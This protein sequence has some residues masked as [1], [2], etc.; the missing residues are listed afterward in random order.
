MGRENEELLKALREHCSYGDQVFVAEVASIDE[1]LDTVVI[2]VNGLELSSVRLRS[3]IDS[4]GN[5]VV[6]YP[7]VDSTVLVGRIGH[8]N[9]M[10]VQAV[11]VVDKVLC[12]IGDMKLE[13]TEAGFVYNEG[14]HT[15]ANADVLKSEL[16]KLTK[17]VDDLLNA[18][19]QASPDS[20]S[21]TFK[22]SLTPLLARITDKENFSGIENDKIKH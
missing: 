11:G 18:L 15:T 12:H 16:N 21:G 14:Q 7:A 1:D 22:A 4:Q 9:E 5:R 6:V 2:Q 10:Y 19:N 3:I 17:R 20:S 8:S 13:V